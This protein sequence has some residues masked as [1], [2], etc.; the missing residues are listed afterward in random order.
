MAEPAI[1]QDHTVDVDADVRI[2]VRR[3]RCRL[4]VLMSFGR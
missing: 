4:G 2:G 1:Q 3:G